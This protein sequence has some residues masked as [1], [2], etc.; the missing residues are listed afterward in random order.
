MKKV[1]LALITAS[2]LLGCKDK[3]DLFDFPPYQTDR[4]PLVVLLSAV[5]SEYAGES[6]LPVFWGAVSDSFGAPVVPLVAHA[7]TVGDPFYSLA[8]SQFFSLYEAELFPALGLNATGF[9]Y[10]VE[11]WLLATRESLIDLS[12]GQ[13][14]PARPPLVLA[15]AKRVVDRDLQIKVR[16]RMEDDFVNV[17]MHLAVY[18]TE[19]EVA[20]GQ[21]GQPTTINHRY[22]LRGA[23]TPGAW[24]IPLGSGNFSKGQVLEYEMSFPINPFMNANQLFVNAVVYRM[25]N[26]QPVEVMNANFR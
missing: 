16:M 20:M 24:G 3:I 9:Q 23:A 6:G 25:E 13:P 4:K 26:E 17:P 2:V 10:R 5:W 14:L 22:V 19:D 12:S 18:V 11:D 15:I 21:E 7:S 1:I 8:A